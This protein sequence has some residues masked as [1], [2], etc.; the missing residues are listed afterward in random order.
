MQGEV[1]LSNGAVLF[2]TVQGVRDPSAAREGDC[3]IILYI[4]KSINRRNAGGFMT[5][6]FAVL[7]EYPFELYKNLLT[8]ALG[9]GDAYSS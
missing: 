3:A 1:E 7:R 5:E 4:H 2:R 6:E 9:S 8:M